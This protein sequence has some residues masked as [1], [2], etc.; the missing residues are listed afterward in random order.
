MD[1]KSCIVY[2]G[3]KFLIKWYYDRNGK[4]AAFDYFLESSKEQRRKFYCCTFAGAW[5]E[6]RRK[7]QHKRNMV[8][9]PFTGAWIETP[10]KRRLCRKVK[11]NWP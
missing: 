10:R 4:S 3:S 5:I 2:S 6:T 7:W 9:A 8:V 1:E 11:K